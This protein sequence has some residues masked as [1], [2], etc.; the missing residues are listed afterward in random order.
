MTTT[1][2]KAARRKEI[3]AQRKVKK[4]AMRAKRRQIKAQRAMKKAGYK[5]AKRARKA[6]RRRVI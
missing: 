2:Q 3:K 4:D 6:G 5:A 1:A